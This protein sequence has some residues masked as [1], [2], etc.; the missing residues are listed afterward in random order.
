MSINFNL[1]FSPGGLLPASSEPRAYVQEVDWVF[2]GQ[3]VQLTPVEVQ[4]QVRRLRRDGV[5]WVDEVPAV[6]Q[7]TGR[8]DF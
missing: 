4:A 3:D 5:A 2:H 8:C 6:P 1:W 7:V